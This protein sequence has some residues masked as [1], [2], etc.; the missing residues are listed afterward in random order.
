MKLP[1]R[2]DG[3]LDG[4]VSVRVV[5]LFLTNGGLAHV[6]AANFGIVRQSVELG[7]NGLD[8]I[9]VV[10]TFKVGSANGAWEEGI[11]HDNKALFLA[12]EAYAT[13]SV[14]RGMQYFK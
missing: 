8:Q 6:T 10:T 14:T 4:L 13:R 12:V 5:G 9:S 2:R 11:A 3:T 1:D 7:L